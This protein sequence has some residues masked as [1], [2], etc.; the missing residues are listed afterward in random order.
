MEECGLWDRKAAQ[1]FKLGLMGLTS[2][3]MEDSSAEGDLNCGGPAQEVSEEK[4]L[5]C[6]LKTIIIVI[7]WQRMW[8]LSALVRF[9]L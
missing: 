5:V 2:W 1:C 9:M 7:V 6:I 3:S 4:I 8:L